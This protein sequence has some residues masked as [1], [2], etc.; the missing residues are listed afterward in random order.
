VGLSSVSCV[1]AERCMAVGG[2]GRVYTFS[3]GPMT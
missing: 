1:T 2:Q 3:S